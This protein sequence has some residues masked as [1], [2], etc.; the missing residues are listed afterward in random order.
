MKTDLSDALHSAARAIDVPEGDL[1]NVIATAQRRTRHRR[2]LVTVMTSVVLLVAMVAAVAVHDRGD[3]GTQLKVGA[4][5]AQQG[6]VGIEWAVQSNFA[7]GPL[8]NTSEIVEASGTLY[9][10]STAPGERSFDGPRVVW[11]STNGLDWSPGK[12]LDD[13]YLSDMAVHDDRLYAVGTSPASLRTTRDTE[14]SYPVIAWS[15]DKALSWQRD[16]L[17]I[18]MADIVDRSV[19][20]WSS[21]SA[22]AVGEQGLVV[23]TKVDA[24][25]DVT[26]M[27]PPGTDLSDGWAVG[28]LGIDLL[29]PGPAQCPPG[30]ELQPELGVV[31][32]AIP[33]DGQVQFGPCIRDYQQLSGQ[34]S[35]GV[36]KTFT[37]E[38]LDVRGDFL[39]AI[40]GRPFVFRSNKDGS[41]RKVDVPFSNGAWSINVTGAADGS[42]VLRAS[43][44]TGVDIFASGDGLTWAKMPAVPGMDYLEAG[45]QLGDRT[46]LFGSSVNSAISTFLLGG[47]EGWQQITLADLAGIDDASKAQVQVAIGSKGAASVVGL[48]GPSLLE[49]GDASVTQVE[50]ANGV[51]SVVPPEGSFAFQGPPTQKKIMASRDGQTWS[52]VPLEDLVPDSDA[53]AVHYIHATPRG[54][55]L[56]LSRMG[57][58]VAG[59]QGRVDVPREWVTI[60]G[61]FD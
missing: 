43:G 13:L 21:N 1:A 11:H 44:S 25:P 48:R 34:D 9:A 49:P 14:V 18:D 42:F 40:L 24:V 53:M 16:R 37:W 58:P 19:S 54:F 28:P 50:V 33:D 7:L 39:Q 61:T 17:P 60:V 5:F 41:L 59:P 38:E 22:V 46:A 56:Y 2:G 10:L 23:V 36:A 31:Q 51:A 3:R 30:S 52:V 45:G 12:P 27:L 26:S 57:Q 29:K 6:D 55:I 8:V 15:D 32:P 35:F 20:T 47:A 4:A